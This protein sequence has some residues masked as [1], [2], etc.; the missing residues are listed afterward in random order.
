MPHET[1]NGPGKTTKPRFYYGWIIV[2]VIGLGGFTQSAESYPILGVFMKPITEE[3]QWSRTIFSGSTLIGTLIGGLVAMLV[4]SMIDRLGAR[5]TLTAAFAVLGCLLILM[6]FINAFWQ[7]YMLQI[8]GRALTM[9]ILALALGI[10]VPK[11]FNY[12]AGRSRGPRWPW[13]LDRQRRYAPLCAVPCF[14]R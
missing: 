10:V 3:F 9:G 2:V 13:S 14:P 7:F 11:W 5:W 8:I 12:Q 4:G 1:S 6:V